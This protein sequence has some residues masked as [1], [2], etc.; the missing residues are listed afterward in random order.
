MKP[1]MKSNLVIA[2]LVL[3]AANLQAASLTTY[4]NE[5]SMPVS[6]PDT[7]QRL[8]EL[9]GTQ[10]YDV[11]AMQKVA[12]QGIGKELP[13][14]KHVSSFVRR[15]LVAKAKE[16]MLKDLY[17]TPEL[18]EPSST[19]TMAQV[20]A[21]IAARATAFCQEKVAP[22]YDKLIKLYQDETDAPVIESTVS[23]V[24]LSAVG[25]S[26]RTYL[27]G[28]YA[29]G[30]HPLGKLAGV[31]VEEGGLSRLVFVK[32]SKL[33]KIS[34]TMLASALSGEDF[35][36]VQMLSCFDSLVAQKLSDLLAQIE[37]G[38]STDFAQRDLLI[39]VNQGLNSRVVKSLEIYKELTVLAPKD[40]HALVNIFLV[41]NTS[42][43]ASSDEWD[44]L[45]FKLIDKV[46]AIESDAEKVK[47]IQ[48]DMNFFQENLDALDTI[49]DALEQ[50]ASKAALK[51]ELK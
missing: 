50:A 37:K 48:A 4:L 18:F 3:G 49:T 10:G 20:E 9:M 8:R 30:A 40:I 15:N 25:T 47:T 26:I 39:E 34:L 17:D 44:T 24:D 23:R 7:H 36:F 6:P 45:K 13:R 29:D 42:A 19:L 32:D 12:V 33:T 31:E 1:I 11:S 43:Y 51:K 5:F 41:Y 27:Q 38:K 35:Y 16:F 21:K 2:T 28:L 46:A 22:D 14:K